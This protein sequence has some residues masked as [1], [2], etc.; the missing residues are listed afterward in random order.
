M[1]KLVL[2]FRN[3]TLFFFLS[4]VGMGFM[5]YQLTKIT[6]SIDIQ[7]FDIFVLFLSMIFTTAMFWIP[8]QYNEKF[9]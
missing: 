8:Y 1:V 5:I 4:G 7:A 2:S 3:K 9:I 6:A